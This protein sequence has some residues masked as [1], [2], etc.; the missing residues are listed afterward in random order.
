MVGGQEEARSGIVGRSGFELAS[1]Q[2]FLRAADQPNGAVV[3]CPPVRPNP[4]WLFSSPVLS[5]FFF[6]PGSWVY[7]S[8]ILRVW[9]IVGGRRSVG[10]LRR[11]K[12]STGL[13]DRSL[14]RAIDSYPTRQPIQLLLGE[15]RRAVELLQDGAAAD[16]VRASQWR[17]AI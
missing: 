14:E 8:S 12:S 6:L 15:G 11:G 10:R 4:L 2:R 16:V 3:Q 13:A 7:P 1:L 17:R 5:L 9:G